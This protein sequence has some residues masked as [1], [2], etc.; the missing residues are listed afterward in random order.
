MAIRHGYHIHNTARMHDSQIS[1][2]SPRCK[3]Y[4]NGIDGREV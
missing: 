1:H 4:G 3:N 2:F